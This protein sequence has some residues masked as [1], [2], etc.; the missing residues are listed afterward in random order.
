MSEQ[1][2]WEVVPYG[3]SFEAIKVKPESE[4]CLI[5]TWEKGCDAP[6]KLVAAHNA[7]L[8][9]EREAWKQAMKDAINPLEQELAAEREKFT[10]A[11]TGV[12]K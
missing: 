11:M 1:Q 5:G 10:L 12:G 3:K 8:A 4:G 9:A 6:R 7:A 2:E